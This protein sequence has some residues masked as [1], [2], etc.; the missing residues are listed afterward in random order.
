MASVFLTFLCSSWYAVV[1]RV[2]GG[3]SYVG[4]VGVLSMDAELEECDDVWME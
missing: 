1:G 3:V 2:G 4:S